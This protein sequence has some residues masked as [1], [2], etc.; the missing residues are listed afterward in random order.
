VHSYS[1]DGAMTFHHIGDRATYAPNS[2]GG[3][4]AD[5]SVEPPTWMVEAA[6][7][8][9]YADSRHAG[10]DDFGQA[11][12]LVREVLDDD[13]RDRMVDNIVAHASAG[14]S[15]AVQSRVMA[16]WKSVDADL[17]ARVVA[18]LGFPTTTGAVR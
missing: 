9:R 10:D 13:Q 12:A 1:K 3:P 2:Y 18:G 4:K 14:V 7:I 5:P 15:P 8:G 6:E 16:Y 11:G 17:G